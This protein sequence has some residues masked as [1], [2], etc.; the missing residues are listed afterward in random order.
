[1]DV[2]E[3]AQERVGFF[4]LAGPLEVEHFV[5]A[6]ADHGIGRLDLVQQR[7]DLDQ[8]IA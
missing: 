3:E 5:L 4:V 1:M 7:P 6:G 8:Q 2:V